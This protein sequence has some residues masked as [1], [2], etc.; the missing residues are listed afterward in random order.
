MFEIENKIQGNKLQL[1]G[2]LT[3]SLIHEIR[4][5]LS[6]I[7]L[8]IDFL[9]MIGDTLPEEALESIEVSRDALDRIQYLIDNILTFTRINVKEQEACSL[10]EISRSTIDLISS[11]ATKKNVHLNLELDEDLPLGFFDKNKILQ[12]FINLVTNA[13]ES[14]EKGGTVSVRTRVDNP[15]YII[16][17]VED[18]GAGIC[19]DVKEKIFQDF[20]TSKEKGTGLGLSVCKMILQQYQAELDFES[21]IGVGTKFLIKFNPNLMRSSDEVQN[22]N[23]R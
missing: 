11:S 18:N 21:T 9:T 6:A 23:S 3:A 12:V 10:N 8:N 14:C 1:L 13:V 20:Y 4:N 7:K 5:P 17:E 15:D 19:D 2:K 16:W 22:I